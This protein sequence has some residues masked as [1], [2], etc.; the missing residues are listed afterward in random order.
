VD[1]CPDALINKARIAIQIQPSRCQS[2][3]SGRAFNRYGNYVFNFNRPDAYL[4]WSRRVLNRYGN[5]VLKINCSNGH[6]FGPDAR[7]L[8]WKLLVADVR[9]SERQC[10]TVRTRILNKKDF[11]RKSQ[12]FYRTVVCPDGSGPPSRRR[13]YLS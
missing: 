7:S 4:S 5:C 10:L 8:I 12:K 11:Q 2:A 13:L 3:W 6:P 9:L 1:S